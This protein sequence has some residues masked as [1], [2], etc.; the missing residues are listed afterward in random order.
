VSKFNNADKHRLLVVVNAAAQIGEVITIGEDP[1]VTITSD[2]KEKGI[3]IVG[4]GTPD[5]KPISQK[6]EVVF[7][8][9]LQEPA[10]HLTAEAN[11]VPVVVFEQCGQVKGPRVIQTL[12]GMYQGVHHTIESF[13]SEF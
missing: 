8:I 7:S 3:T 12:T 9:Q 5:P 13:N 10:P 4:F 1:T 6:G 2:R 11:L